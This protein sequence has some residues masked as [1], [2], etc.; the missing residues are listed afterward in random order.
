MRLNQYIALHTGISRRRADQ[1]I[2]DE[3]VLVN[4]GPASLGH[5][6]SD[7]DKVVVNG[8][9]IKI[10]PK[11]TTIILNKPVGYVVS[12]NG[13]GSKTIY[14]LL[15]PELHNLKPVGRLDK[16]SSG[17]LLLTNNGT[18]ANE[19]TH[20]SNKKEKIYEVETDKPLKHEDFEK[21]IKNGVNIG[22]DK[23]SRFQLVAS[24]KQQEVSKTAS[25]HPSYFLPSTYYWRATLTEGRNR[26]IRRT[27]EALGYKVTK[28]HRTQFGEY[29]LSELR[30]GTFT[31]T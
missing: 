25:K 18:L 28:L 29:K 17:L 15:P 19:L 10:K 23:L 4:N 11:I 3:K 7:Q 14:D 30:L 31:I 8:L 21:I 26:Q 27:F 22:D 24:S 5:I 13:Q 6:V 2:K 16:D 1:L 20:P 9:E 12:R